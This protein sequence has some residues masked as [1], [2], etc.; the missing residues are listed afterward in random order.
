M[1]QDDQDL[2]DVMDSALKRQ[3]EGRSQRFR[4]PGEE[5]P[6]RAENPARPP[7][8]RAEPA[9]SGPTPAPQAPPAAPAGGASTRS[10]FPAAEATIHIPEYQRMDGQ[11]NTQEIARR[12]YPM[13]DSARIL[14]GSG[15]MSPG[16]VLRGTLFSGNRFRPQ[17]GQQ[18]AQPAAAPQPLAEQS[19]PPPPTPPQ[20]PPPPAAEPPAQAPATQQLP[21][22]P[23]TRQAP[24]RGIA[25]GTLRSRPSGLLTP[26]VR[27]SGV[28]SPQAPA[29]S[30]RFEPPPAAPAPVQ[31]GGFLV[32]TEV[33]IVAVVCTMI[34]LFCAFLLGHRMGESSAQR[35]SPG[36]A[37][38]SVDK[39]VAV[40]EVPAAIPSLDRPAPVSA[41]IQSSALPAVTAPPARSTATTPASPGRYALRMRSYN[42]KGTAERLVAQLRSKGFPDPRVQFD[43]G[44]HKVLVGHF[45]SANDPGLK[46]LRGKVLAVREWSSFNPD[47]FPKN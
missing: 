43:N 40:S 47:V 42:D 36:E 30:N 19:A 38:T 10:E 27:P 26:S 35:K 31:T 15:A 6:A 21:S 3:G 45:A 16:Q 13:P 20:P 23:S 24:V 33:A 11:P 12:L 22:A 7:S 37:Q 17:P 8:Q 29:T 34:A 14:P 41:P 4:A 28:L 5:R 25:S 2:F 18:P 46:E 44:V 9:R 39:P 1:P 32:R